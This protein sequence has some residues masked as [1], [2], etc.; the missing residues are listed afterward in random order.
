M[1]IKT[2]TFFRRMR[3]ATN[4]YLFALLTA[5]LSAC[6]SVQSTNV[7]EVGLERKQYFKEGVREQVVKYA[8]KAYDQDLLL[9]L[10]VLSLN[11][12][13]KMTQ[14][15]VD[16]SNRL[17]PQVRHF[18][19]DA[20]NWAWEVNITE[21]KDT[22]NAYC[23]AGGKIM[24]YSGLIDMANDDELAAVIGHEIGH[25]LRDHSAERLSTEARNNSVSS[26]LTSILGVGVALAT[27]VDLT[28]TLNTAGRLGTEALVNLP[29]SREAEH[30]ADLIGLELIARAGFDPRAAANFWRK[31]IAAEKAAGNEGRSHSIWSTHPSNESRLATLSSME[32]RV[33]PLYAH[34]QE[35]NL[36]EKIA[37]TVQTPQKAPAASAQSSNENMATSKNKKTAAGK[38]AAKKEGKR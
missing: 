19:P 9:T 38:A 27:G 17:I 2:G 35:Q 11:P 14:R 37:T 1:P 8:A 7:G 32:A 15:V 36:Q 23:M 30:E 20:E 31:M 13:R 34:A 18:R 29:N 12:D 28:K 26:T 24:V 4:I 33:L 10:S 22:I 5:L 6:A 21:D 16:I 25:A 3:V